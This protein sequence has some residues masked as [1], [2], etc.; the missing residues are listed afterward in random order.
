MRT[1][2][3][4]V[5]GAESLGER[6]HAL[7]A[8]LTAALEELRT[9]AASNRQLTEQA[10]GELRRVRAE[11]QPNGG[12]S[13]HD[14]IQ[15]IAAAQRAQDDRDATPLFWSDASGRLTH[16]NRAYL[17]LSGRTREELVGT[18][19]TNFIAPA[20]RPRV[21]ERWREAVLEA[22]DFDEIFAVQD[23]HGFF[24]CQVHGR[25]TRLLNGSGRLLGYYG[26]LQRLG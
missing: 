20:D 3:H 12:G 6:L 26:E 15:A 16:V 4:T 8:T 7:S 21:I 24:G 2:W 13:L 14:V 19:W 1:L 11:L 5:T 23:L 18:G 10:V 17:Q 22:R 25:A 9:E